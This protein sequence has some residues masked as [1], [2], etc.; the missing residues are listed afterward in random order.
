MSQHT[1]TQTHK[2]RIPRMSRDPIGSN[3]HQELLSHEN[4]GKKIRAVLN[5]RLNSS[6]LSVTGPVIKNDSEPLTIL[7]TLAKRGN[8]EV[9]CSRLYNPKGTPATTMAYYAPRPAEGQAPP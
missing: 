8:S 2:L 6:G 5:N 7:T 3:N 4:D 1:H 9:K